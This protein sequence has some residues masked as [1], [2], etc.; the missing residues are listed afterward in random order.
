MAPRVICRPL[1]TALPLAVLFG[2]QLVALGLVDTLPSAEQTVREEVLAAMVQLGLRPLILALVPA[3]FLTW[4]A[5]RWLYL[6]LARI[7]VRGPDPVA[8]TA[9]WVLVWVAGWLGVHWLAGPQDLAPWNLAMFSM[10]LVWY[11]LVAMGLA[12]WA[13]AREGLPTA[14]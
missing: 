12:L 5:T 1:L 7:G 3:A 14:A 13:G 4:L 6:R 8:L 11:G 2:V 9:G 10:P